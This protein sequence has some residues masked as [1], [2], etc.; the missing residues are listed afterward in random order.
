MEEKEVRNEWS[1]YSPRTVTNVIH[2]SKVYLPAIE[3][4]VSPEIVWALHSFLEFCYLVWH[5][6]ITDRSLTEIEDALK[7]FHENQQVFHPDI[8]S[9]FSLPRQHGM[10]HYLELIRLF[11]APNGLCSSITESK[12][13]KA[14][15]EP[16]QHS[17]HHIVLGQML[18]TNQPL[19]KLA[20]ARVDFNQHGMRKGSCTSMV[21][22]ELGTYSLASF[23]H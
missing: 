6:T 2:Y 7:R 3:G 5:N 18:L 9:T 14:A 15:K 21:A 13:I 17:N 23:V 19:D 1:Q 8:V 11:G 4:H 20:R 22:C 12:H 10:K 16:Y